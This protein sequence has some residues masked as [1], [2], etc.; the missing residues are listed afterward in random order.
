[1]LNDSAKP[2]GSASVLEAFPGKPEIKIRRTAKI[3]K[4]NNQVSPR[5]P[6]SWQSESKKDAYFWFCWYF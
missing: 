5:I 2:G 3:E 1:M 6:H 4:R